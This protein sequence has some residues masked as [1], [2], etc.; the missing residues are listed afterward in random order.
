MPKRATRRCAST[1]RGP[2]TAPARQGIQDRVD[3]WT[4]AVVAAATWLTGSTASGRVAVI[5]LGLGGLITGHAIAAGAPIDELVLWAA[6]THGRSI[7][8]EQRAFGKLQS[9]RYGSTEGTEETL[10]DG[11][12]EIGGFVQS[13]GTIA[14]IQ[15]L[16]LRGMSLGSLQRVLLLERDGLGVDA[17]LQ[18]HLAEAGVDVTVAPGPGWGDMCFHPEQYQ[19]P[20]DVIRRVTDWLGAGAHSTA[21][22][23]PARRASPP[24]SSAD[25]QVSVSVDGV[26]IRET[27]LGDGATAGGFFGLVAEPLVPG[28][29]DMCA[30]FLNAGAVR[31]I[32]PNRMWVEA[33]R[34]WA[35]RGIPTVRV[36]VEGIGDAQGDGAM[37]SDVGSFY[38][39]D[40]EVQ[41]S[42]IIDALE[43]R[44]LGP[45]FV[46]IGLCAGAYSAFN[47]AVA[48]SRIVAA[49]AVN[50][51]L[52]VWD[53]A[54]LVRRNA[55]LVNKVLDRGSWQRLLSGETTPARI[56]AIGRAAAAEAP[57][58][59]RRYASRLRGGQQQDSWLEDAGGPVRPASRRPDEDGPGVRG[60]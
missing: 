2:A 22:P 23:R 60:G 45:R 32:G 25:G 41:V 5:G 51:R 43:A 42:A 49:L 54:I 4:A 7:L 34:R 35:A 14:A 20:F 31:R 53:P 15:R 58:A 9:D 48:D 21:E 13:A 56:L 1:S 38:T 6:P 16:D 47:T 24:R 8:R 12:R 57:R 10:P 44:G 46:L 39:P 33:A 18:R 50:P 3:A 36:D 55:H 52:V 40:R 59:A 17:G 29:A 30:V 37:Y 19:P 27:P 28:H 11:W 26:Q